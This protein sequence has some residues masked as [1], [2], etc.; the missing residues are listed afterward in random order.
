MIKNWLVTGDTHGRVM[1]RLSQI[2]SDKY[3]P[4][5]TAIIIL[6]DAGIN[7]FLNKTDVKNKKSIQASG[8]TIYCVRGNHEMRPERL[9]AI[10]CAFDFEVQGILRYEE[11]YPHIKYLVNNQIYKFGDYSAL[12]IEGAYSVDKY[13]RLAGTGLTGE[14]DYELV[15]KKAGWFKDEQLSA[16]E[17]NFATLVIKNKQVDFV[18]SH[19]CPLSWQPVDLFLSAVN[20]STVDNTMEKWLDSLKNEFQWKIWLFGHFHKDR[21]ERPHVEQFFQDIQPIDSIYNRWYGEK[22]IHKEWYLEK[23]PNYY[24]KGDTPFDEDLKEEL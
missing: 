4:D 18:L 9:P 16:E 1:E 8:Y 24:L 19:T 12:V 17:M 2:D 7:Y 14:E 5:E 23:S 3:I 6:G 21:I 15:A 13:Y 11:D 22:T 20:Q 10:N